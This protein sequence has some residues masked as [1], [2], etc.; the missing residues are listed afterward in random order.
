MFRSI[1]VFGD[2]PEPNRSWLGLLL[3]RA[4]SAA[5]RNVANLFDGVLS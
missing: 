1:A 4:N 5:A 2:E 3:V